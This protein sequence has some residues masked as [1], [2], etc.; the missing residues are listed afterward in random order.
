MERE[1]CS[2]TCGRSSLPIL[3]P[4]LFVILTLPRAMRL[5]GLAACCFLTCL[6]ATASAMNL[7]TC[8]EYEVKQI[9]WSLKH[10]ADPSQVGRMFQH[11]LGLLEVLLA[12]N[13]QTPSLAIFLCAGGQL[14]EELGISSSRM[15]DIIPVGTSQQAYMKVQVQSVNARP[16]VLINISGCDHRLQRLGTSI[17]SGSKQWYCIALYSDEEKRRSKFGASWG[18]PARVLPQIFAH[19][20]RSCTDSGLR[21]SS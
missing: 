4:V 3:G 10:L 11:T 18:M 7:G 14:V 13:N 1:R 5:H 17:Q 16:A 21:D 12:F 6:D 20:S 9:P 19:A 15:A 8:S 2:L